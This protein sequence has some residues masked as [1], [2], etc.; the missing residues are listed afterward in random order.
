[1]RAKE[2]LRGQRGFSLAETLLAVLIL[3]LVSVIVATG[4]PAA[5]NAY[6]RVVVA[7]NAQALLSTAAT[8]L[9]NELGTAWN[10]IIDDST[11]KTNAGTAGSSVTYNSANTG[12]LSKIALDED[13]GITLQEYKQVN[14]FNVADGDQ[15]SSYFLNNNED[16]SLSQSRRLVS[17]KTGAGDSSGKLKV[18]YETVSYKDDC[19]VF[20]KLSAGTD[21]YPKLAVIE[22]L[23]IPVISAK[24]EN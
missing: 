7:S 17:E 9:R 16:S 4:M 1:M 3:L 21:A 11:V 2:K 13:T 20:S 8:S 23:T 14:V 24:T 15:P 12:G 5:K 19:V 10:V 22:T 6:E 18:A